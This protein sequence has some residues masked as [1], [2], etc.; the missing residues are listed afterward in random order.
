MKKQ[1]ER[2][3][4]EEREH[5]GEREKRILKPNRKQKKKKK[6]E[7]QNKE[8]GRER[9]RAN[10]TLGNSCSAAVHEPRHRSATSDRLLHARYAAFPLDFPFVFC[11]Q[12][13]LLHVACRRRAGG[14]KIIL[15]PLGC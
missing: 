15:P 4:T 6:K 9:E 5:A 1:R 3:E 2:E 11:L 10:L 8:K 13:R 14:R 12:F 7:N